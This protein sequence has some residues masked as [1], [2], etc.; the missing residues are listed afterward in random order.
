MSIGYGVETWCLDSLQPGRLA[1][2]RQVVAQAL[3]RRLIT[4]RGML[5]GG[6][7][8]AAYGLDLAGYVGSV[9]ASIAVAALPSLIRHELRKDD[10]VSDVAVSVA[11]VPGGG[12]TSLAISIYVTL[13]DD[14]EAF[15]LTL[16]ADAV[17]VALVGG[18]P[19]P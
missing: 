5:R 19:T 3:Y 18:M 1:R 6:A 13:S 2:G 12:T 16:E 8:E 7:E 9:G 4:P 10:R 14:S 15:Q 11:A 17:T